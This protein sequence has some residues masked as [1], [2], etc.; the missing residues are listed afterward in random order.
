MS[1]TQNLPTSTDKFLRRRT[2]AALAFL[3]TVYAATY[4][5]LEAA[6]TLGWHA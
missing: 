6:F 4:A 5:A 2:I 1:C 3:G